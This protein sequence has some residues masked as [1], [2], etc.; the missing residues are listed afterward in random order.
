VEEKVRELTELILTTDEKRTIVVYQ[1][2]DYVS[3]MVKKSDGSRSLPD[4]GQDGRYHVE[5]KLDIASREEAKRMVSKAIPLLRAGGQCRKIILTP[6]ARFKCNPCCYTKGH[7]S[8]LNEKNYAEWME[9]K[10][11]EMRGVMIDYVR[12][13]NIKRATVMEF[14]KLITPPPAGM[15]SYVQDEEL[16]GDFPKVIALLRPVWSH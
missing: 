10:L 3:L 13:R 12:I 8:N 6:A 11:A 16:W 4:K 5:G 15:S 14:G 2:F 1:V 7:C 9:E